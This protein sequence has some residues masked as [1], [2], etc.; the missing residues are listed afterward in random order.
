MREQQIADVNAV[1]QEIGADNV[2]QI[3][4]YNKLDAAR[5]IYEIQRKKLQLAQDVHPT[6]VERD[7]DQTAATADVNAPILDA[8][9]VLAPAGGLDAGAIHDQY[10]KVIAVRVSALTGEGFDAL[11]VALLAASVERHP[12]STMPALEIDPIAA[13]SSQVNLL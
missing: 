4:V 11:R 2:P 3:I 8:M 10:G 7:A 9:K 5:A 12:M 13:M 6:D 1:L